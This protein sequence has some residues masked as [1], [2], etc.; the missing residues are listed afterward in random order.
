KPIADGKDF[1]AAIL[2]P[3]RRTGRPPAP[4]DPGTG[5]GPADP[6]PPGKPPEEDPSEEVSTLPGE[7]D[8]RG[9]PPGGSAVRDWSLAWAGVLVA[10]HAGRPRR[11]ERRRTPAL[12][13]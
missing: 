13:A 1:G 8:S 6:G 11:A 5:D 2:N 7:G 3:T 12:T 10:I 4:D 9:R